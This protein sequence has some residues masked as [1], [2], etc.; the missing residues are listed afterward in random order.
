MARVRPLSNKERNE[1][2]AECI[3][4]NS[5]IHEILVLD[6]QAADGKRR[7]EFDSVFG[8]QA[9][10][11]EVYAG[12]AG[13]LIRDSIYKGFNGTILAYGQTGSGEYLRREVLCHYS[14]PIFLYIG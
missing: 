3:L 10:Q 14:Y 9:S 8:P 2:S 12:T 1:Q 5:A 7:F 6:G 13:N 11:E 4:A